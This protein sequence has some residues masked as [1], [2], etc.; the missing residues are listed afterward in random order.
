LHL[1]PNIQ[2]PVREALGQHPR[3]NLVDPMDYLP[4]VALME[5]SYLI[6]TDSGGVQEEA[7]ALGKPVLVLR[8]NSEAPARR[9]GPVQRHEPVAQPLW[10]R[11][12]SSAN[13]KA[14]SWL[15]PH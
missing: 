12:G 10:R 5:A 14:R 8:D 13:C 7:P 3:I 1:N 11:K 2:V 15:A 9:S 6:L 4:F